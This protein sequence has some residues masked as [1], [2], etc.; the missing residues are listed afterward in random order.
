MPSITNFSDYPSTQADAVLPP[1]RSPAS[2]GIPSVDGSVSS[3]SQD[4]DQPQPNPDQ[5]RQATEQAENQKLLFDFPQAKPRLMRLRQLWRHEI[6][7][8]IER[9][10]YRKVDISPK[11]LRDEGKLKPDETLIPLRVIDTNIRRE[12]PAYVNYLISPP[13]QYV[14]ECLDNAQV[15]SQTSR[16]LEKDVTTCLR[17]PAWEMPHFKCM[18]GSQL[19]G[20]DSVEVT[21]DESKPGHIG[22]EH[23]GHDN[24]YFGVDSI[25]TQAGECMM[26]RYSVTVM[27]LRSWIVQHGF[28]PRQTQYLLDFA[29]GLDKID[30][31]FSVYKVYIKWQGVVYI[32]WC[33]LEYCDDWLKKP[34]KL[35]MGIAK[36]V[37]V[38][39]PTMVPNPKAG[40]LN[41]IG[42]ALKLVQPEPSH[43]QTMVPTMEW[44]E[45]DIVDYPIFLNIYLINEEQPIMQGVGRGF[46]DK[47]KQEAMTAI[48]TGYVNG[49]NRASNVYG[50]VAGDPS[51]TAEPVQLKTPLNNGALYDKKIEF[52]TT[53]YPDPQ[54]LTALEYFGTQNTEETGQVAI[55]AQNRQDSRKTAKEVEGAENTQ[56]EL[57]TVQ[58]A[59]YSIFLT[60]LGAFQW[61]ILQSQA[62]QNKIPL[63]QIPKPSLAPNGQQTM[64]MVNNT[65]LLK[66]RF[67][68]R[69]AGSVDVIERQKML[70]QMRQ[71]WP[72]MQQS[73]LAMEFFKEFIRQAYPNQANSWIAVMDQ[74]Q[75]TKQLIQ[76]LAQMLEYL[77]KQDQA[78]LTPQD[79]NT[80][81]QVEQEVQQALQPQAPVQMGQQPNQQMAPTPDSNIGLGGVGFNIQQ[82]QPVQ[83]VTQ[84]NT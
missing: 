49:L 77:A 26:R 44:Q 6:E 20:W 22:L 34:E 14:F 3:L 61:L 28:D 48:A 54:C 66:L 47:Y 33:C 24:L 19:H 21:Y 23:V 71:D 69:P 68:V 29:K 8:T 83:Q 64:E 30:Y 7:Q 43:V 10:L 84:G 4:P 39:K 9:R 74:S 67:M 76:K 82:D 81:K 1:A 5:Q 18:D 53:P 73:P 59:L 32:A 27:Q 16:N 42:A 80:L 60:K 38:M 70:Q 17:Y 37:Q 58:V 55:A 13:R 51:S 63:L 65:D 57:S 46:L 41:T 78:K 12:N 56:A 52:F 25:D 62:L 11:K 75:Q 50:S 15:D 35:K 40:P 36:Q 2:G 45:Q 79:I 72:V 31:N